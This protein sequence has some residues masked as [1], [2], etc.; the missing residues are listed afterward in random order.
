MKIRVQGTGVPCPPVHSGKGEEACHIG[1]LEPP[2][3]TNE[4]LTYWLQVEKVTAE[5]FMVDEAY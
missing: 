3:L 1:G 4:M 2:P 5:E